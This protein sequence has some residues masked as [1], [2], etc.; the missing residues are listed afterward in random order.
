MKKILSR[1]ISVLLTMSFILPVITL[2]AQA[3]AENTD[4]LPYTVDGF[5]EYVNQELSAKYP[6]IP[7]INNVHSLNSNGTEFNGNWG[8]FCELSFQVEASAKNFFALSLSIYNPQTIDSSFLEF[9]YLS[10]FS[11]AF[12]N[13]LDSNSAT[14]ENLYYDLFANEDMATEQELTATYGNITHSYSVT[15]EK[16][17]Y[18]LSASN[19]TATVKTKIDENDT[20]EAAAEKTNSGITVSLNGKPLSFKNPAQ[21]VDG[22]VLIPAWD[23]A[24][25]LNGQIQWMQQSERVTLVAESNT[26]EFGIGDTV[27]Y[28]DSNPV[29]VK[30]PALMYNNKVYLPTEWISAVFNAQ[31]TWDDASKTCKIVQKNK[32]KA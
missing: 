13:E 16:L 26:I 27:V 20:D 25:E 14:A 3:A 1:L 29:A 22:Q 28:I 17:F 9:S 30:M 31:V 19:M 4:Y 10:L 11:G 18:R 6:D 8:D 5:V 15:G 21:Y 12:F 23:W 24:E 2:S 32:I 7:P